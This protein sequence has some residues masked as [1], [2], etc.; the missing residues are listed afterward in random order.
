MYTFRT[1]NTHEKY[2]LVFIDNA[3]TCDNEVQHEAMIQLLED[4][5]LRSLSNCQC[6]LVAECVVS[7]L[8]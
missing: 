7:C 4:I 8:L 1:A 3:R 6:Q 2:L 5:L